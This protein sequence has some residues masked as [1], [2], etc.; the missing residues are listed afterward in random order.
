MS[1]AEQL[2]PTGLLPGYQEKG[3]AQVG[4]LPC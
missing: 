3:A 4:T 1:R 2:G